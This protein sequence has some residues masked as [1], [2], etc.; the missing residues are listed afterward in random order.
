MV[1]IAKKGFVSI[2]VVITAA[3]VLAVGL[4]GIMTLGGNGASTMN[5]AMNRLEAT[6]TFGGPVAVAS[7]YDDYGYARVLN[8][9]PSD[10]NAEADFT[11]A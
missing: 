3:I 10:I 4:G 7:E 11:Y 9:N 1:K 6:G 5:K 2:E 8:I